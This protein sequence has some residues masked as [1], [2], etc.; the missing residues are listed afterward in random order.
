MPDDIVRIKNL[1][2]PE[3]DKPATIKL[4]Y[5]ALEEGGYKLLKMACRLEM[6]MSFRGTEC[7]HS[8]EKQIKEE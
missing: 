7:Y 8:C 2:C 5:A 1:M 4:T 6:D 3:F